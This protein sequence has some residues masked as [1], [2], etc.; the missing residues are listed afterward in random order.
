MFR[1]TDLCF[2]PPRFIIEASYCNG[3]WLMQSPSLFKVL[4]IYDSEGS[5]VEGT[6]KLILPSKDTGNTEE[7]KEQDKI[8]AG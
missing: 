3:Y 7:E 8:T 5:A 1:S 4:R 2:F 6:F